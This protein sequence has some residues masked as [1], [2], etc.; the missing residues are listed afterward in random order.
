MLQFFI[1]MVNRVEGKQL[2]EN[3]FK[4][5]EL[6]KTVAEIKYAASNAVT[7]L[8]AAQLPLSKQKWSGI[9]IPGANLCKSML[10]G[11]D[12]SGADLTGVNFSS[13]FLNNCNF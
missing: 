13:A 9:R 8:N 12:F 6:S 4:I 1:D 7:I 11:T 2:K 10:S 5:I 3:L